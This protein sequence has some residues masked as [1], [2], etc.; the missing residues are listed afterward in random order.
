MAQPFQS[1]CVVD[2]VSA[3][4]RRVHDESVSRILAVGLRPLRF[5]PGF[6][7]LLPTCPADLRLA[8]VRPKGGRLG[9]IPLCPPPTIPMSEPLGIWTLYYVAADDHLPAVRRHALCLLL[10]RPGGRAAA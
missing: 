10:S 9:S 7:G 8:A 3:S 5:R 6:G 1:H 2:W 4:P